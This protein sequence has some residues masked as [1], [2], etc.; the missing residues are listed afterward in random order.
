MTSPSATSRNNVTAM[1]PAYRT[2]AMLLNPIAISQP[3]IAGNAA[4][5]CKCSHSTEPGIL[6]GAVSGALT[7][8][9]NS[10]AAQRAYDNS[11]Q[12][13]QVARHGERVV[14]I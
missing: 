9:T 8:D 14:R 4:E 12:R 13:G 5:E 11:S 2:T 7:L 3:A 10:G 6:T 1:A